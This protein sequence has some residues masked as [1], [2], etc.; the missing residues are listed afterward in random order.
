[1]PSNAGRAGHLLI[2]E[3]DPIIRQMVAEW[4]KFNTPH[5]ITL[6]AD[7]DE[8]VRLFQSDPAD[9]VL[10]DLRMPGLS[11]VD[12]MDRLKPIQPRTLFILMSGY[13]DVAETVRGLRHGAIDF[14]QKPFKMGNL[15]SCLERAFQQVWAQE[16][17][18]A[19]RS[20]LVEERRSFRV[21]ND[22]E[23]VTHV[24]SELT[25][26]I[27]NEPGLEDLA[28][29]GIRAALHE[30][31]LNAIEHGNLEITYDEKSKLMESPDGWSREIEARAKNPAYRDRRVTVEATQTPD[32]ITYKIRDEGKGFDHSCLPDPAELTFVPHGRGI[33]ITRVHM[34]ELTYNE[35]GNE[36]TM[37][38]Y[39]NH[40]SRQTSRSAA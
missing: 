13:E 27:E 32:A 29:E 22:I 6:A 1:M 34:D 25:R 16:Q 11:G 19:V 35:A 17:R 30:M 7:G 40:S 20:Y 31:I 10:S 21:P 28:L 23:Q 14:F 9:I 4:I 39:K 37:V 15:I 2:A 18:S 38:K 36:V 3:D 12:L 8:A 26:T 24:A 33:L 5:R